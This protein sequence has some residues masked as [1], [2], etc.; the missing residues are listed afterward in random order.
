MHDVAVG[1]NCVDEQTVTLLSAGGGW[2]E[3]GGEVP[4]SNPPRELESV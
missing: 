3:S 2:R 1:R 4:G